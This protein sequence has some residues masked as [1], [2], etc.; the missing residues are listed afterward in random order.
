M[1]PTRI[2]DAPKRVRVTITLEPELLDALKGQA[3]EEDRS[4]SNYA[5]RM[6]RQFLQERGVT[7]EPVAVEEP[8][9]A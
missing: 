7:V 3:T 1:G 9:A 2:P 4:L 8:V 6:I 5:N